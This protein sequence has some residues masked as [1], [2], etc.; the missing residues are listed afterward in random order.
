VLRFCALGR[1]LL[2]V[3]RVNKAEPDFVAWIH[4][5]CLCFVASDWCF[6]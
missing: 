6:V 2:A 5:M 1:L 4:L 3:E